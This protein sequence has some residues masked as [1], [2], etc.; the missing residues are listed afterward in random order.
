VH[1]ATALAAYLE[2]IALNRLEHALETNNLKDRQQFGFCRHKG[3]HDL[4]AHLIAKIA[5]HRVGVRHQYGDKATARQNLSTI[6]SLDVK[7]ASDNVSQVYMIKKMYQELPNDPIRHWIRA[8]IL[9]RS[10]KLKYRGLVSRELGIYKGVP[11]GSALGPILWNYAISDLSKELDKHR[12]QNT[13]IVAYADDITLLSNG[14]NNHKST[15]GLLDQINRY[16]QLRGLEISPEK[17][18]LLHVIGPGRRPKEEEL[19]R[20]MLANHEI[21]PREFI[22]ILGV[23][24][25]K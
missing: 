20:Y 11:Q 13:S 5:E 6:I 8:F 18:E 4:I 3:R 21:A 14:A 24:V 22:K 2:L 15:Q 1:V 12:G 9:N 25:Y 10:I 7:G 23:P 19:P 16:M 17:C